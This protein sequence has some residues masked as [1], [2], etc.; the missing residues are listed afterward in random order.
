MVEM[1]DSKGRFVMPSAE[2]VAALPDDAR[3]KFHTVQEAAT[4]NETC[5]ANL[6]SAYKRVADAIAERDAA[7][8]AIPKR[9]QTDNA[10][11]FIRSARMQNG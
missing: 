4:E 11:D 1:F 8:K 7:Q 6:D 2:D 10:R 3:E 9:T 5:K